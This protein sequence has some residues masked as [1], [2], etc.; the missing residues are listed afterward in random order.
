MRFKDQGVLV[1]GAASGIGE[2]VA[3]AFAREGAVVAAADR[4][5]KG[6]ERVAE[7]ARKAGGRAHAF[8]LDVTDAKAVAAFVEAAGKRLGRLDVLVNSAGVREIMPVLE[9]SLEEWNRVMG[10]NITGTFLCSQAFARA[11]V[12]KGG[13]AAIVNLAS[14]L[15]VVAAPNRAAYTASKHAVVGL[16]KEMA[17]ELG[18]KGIRVNAVGPGVIR[19]P[20]T[21]RY[22]QDAQQ[23]QRIRDV[24]AMG[25]WGEPDEIAR[26]I[27][28]LASEEASFCTGTTLIV[29]GGWTAGKKL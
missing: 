2:K 17:M 14:T 20:L 5:V 13:K 21:E 15:G 18:E 7:A 8:D 24:H 3:H 22:F 19:T 4:D 12:A 1:T 16:T 25:R 26:A 9:L 28:F 10:V 6:A 23:A 27:L 29:D 11:V